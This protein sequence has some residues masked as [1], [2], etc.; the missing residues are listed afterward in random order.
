MHI[1]EQALKMAAKIEDEQHQEDLQRAAQ[2][3]AQKLQVTSFHPPAC[4]EA[5]TKDADDDIR[6]ACTDNPVQHMSI[7]TFLRKITHLLITDLF[8]LGPVRAARSKSSNK[9]LPQSDSIESDD[10]NKDWY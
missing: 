6:S 8:F 9:I 10:S 3:N 7:Y 5:E 2:S 1:Q 4:T